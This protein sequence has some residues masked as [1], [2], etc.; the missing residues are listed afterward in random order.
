M[1]WD[2]YFKNLAYVVASNSKCLSRHIGAVL[3]QNRAVISTGYN[4]APRGI[5]H[6]GKERMLEDKALQ[7]LAEFSTFP[8]VDK[9]DEFASI[10]PRTVLGYTSGEGLHLCPATHAEANCIAQAAMNGVVTKG[11]TMYVTCGVPCKN[12]LALIINAGIKE[13]VC[14]SLEWYD[15]LSPFIVEHSNL[16]IR[17]YEKENK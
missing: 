9:Y 14:T 6:C 3:V 7:I 15:S 11:A 8:H 10:C 16:I 12:C 4:G 2:E 1:K 5:P 13:V 17:E